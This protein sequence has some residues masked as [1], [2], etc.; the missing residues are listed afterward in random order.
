MEAFN[1]SCSN[2]EGGTEGEGEDEEEEEEGGGEGGVDGFGD[3][4]GRGTNGDDG[5]FTVVIA[6]MR[7]SAGERSIGGIG[8]VGGTYWHNSF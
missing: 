7:T 5:V 4:T 6:D 3:G 1:P 8:M 2:G